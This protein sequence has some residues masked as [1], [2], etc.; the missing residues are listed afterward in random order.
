MI[1]IYNTII[2]LIPFTMKK[3]VIKLALIILILICNNLYVFSQS[4]RIVD[5]FNKALIRGPGPNSTYTMNF[6]KG[7]RTLA[8]LKV[9]KHYDFTMVRST[10]YGLKIIKFEF[11]LNKE[12]KPTYNPYIQEGEE[13]ELALNK[14]NEKIKSK[15]KYPYY[16][17]EYN[18]PKKIETRLRPCRIYDVIDKTSKMGYWN[19]DI[20]EGYANGHGIG[21]VNSNAA[22]NEFIYGMMVAGE[23]SDGNPNGYCDIIQTR[24]WGI[25]KGLANPYFYT[26][27]SGKFSDGKCDGEILITASEPIAQGSVNNAMYL[28]VKFSNGEQYGDG[29]IFDKNSKLLAQ[30]TTRNGKLVIEDYSGRKDLNT[31]LTIVGV[32]VGAAIIYEKGLDYLHTY[33]AEH[34]NYG[35]S[36]GSYAAKAPASVSS[37]KPTECVR[38]IKQLYDFNFCGIDIAEAYK[39][40]CIESGYSHT[41]FLWPGGKGKEGNSGCLYDKNQGWR[42]DDIAIDGRIDVHNNASWETAAK[43]VCGC[44]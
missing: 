26:R 1:L 11:R 27:N 2:N 7:V 40:E 9:L 35:T 32:T 36:S 44:E 24:Y 3:I 6:S 37:A 21:F 22:G 20:V 33:Y 29:F 15:L 19:G 28:L 4:K 39:F 16:P 38:L 41:I 42:I 34:R 8:L 14:A 23:L 5:E 17:E 10:T 43:K 13:Q 31:I 12:Y 25:K 18:T 30:G